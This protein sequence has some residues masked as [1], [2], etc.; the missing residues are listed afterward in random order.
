MNWPRQVL[1]TNCRRVQPAIAQ[2]A[3][4]IGSHSGGPA[5]SCAGMKAVGVNTEALLSLGGGPHDRDVRGA[6][7]TL[8]G[9]ENV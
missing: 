3:L 7:T 8:W 6:L 4:S 2:S 9:P 5:M 1:R